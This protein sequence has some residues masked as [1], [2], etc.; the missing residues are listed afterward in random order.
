MREPLLVT[1]PPSR[2][3]QG[4]RLIRLRLRDRP[5]SLAAITRHLAEHRVN[6]LRLEVL[7]REGGWA[8]DDFLVSGAGLSAALAELEPE[9][10]VLANRPNVDLLDP[11]LAMAS[12]CATVTAAVSA[13]EAYRQLVGA[14][15]RLVFAE[16]GF[17]CVR[18]GHGFLRPLA[19]TIAGLPVLDDSATSLLRSA[20]FSGECLTADGRVPWAPDGFRDRLPDGA[21]TAIPGGVP[22]FMV[23]ALVRADKTPFVQAELD[24]LAA[25]VKVASGTLQLHAAAPSIGRRR[26]AAGA[27]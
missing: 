27:A 25:L 15:V 3:P 7:G 21:V 8:V 2:A 4:A 22:P 18:E 26:P 6:V 23:L 20:Y 5:G 13:R 17:V 1:V 16:A 19:S 24:R 12:A 11:G 9:V 14:A 10:T